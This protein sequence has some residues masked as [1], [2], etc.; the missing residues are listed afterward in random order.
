MKRALT[1]SNDGELRIPET[2]TLKA[3]VQNYFR[4]HLVKDP[5]D[6]E[7]KKGSRKG[8]QTKQKPTSGENE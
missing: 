2:A 8:K 1:Q 6:E 4:H 3:S 5:D 7:K